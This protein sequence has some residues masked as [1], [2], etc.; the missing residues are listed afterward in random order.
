MARYCVY[1]GAEES[2]DNPVVNN[3]CLKCRIKR[4]ELVKLK[5]TQLKFDF[6]KI[7]GSVKIGYKWVS[8]NGFEEAINAIVE[9]YIPTIIVSGIGVENISITGYELKSMASWHTVI[10]I[11]MKGVYG[12]KEFTIDKDIELYLNPVKCPRCIM[13]D[14]REFEAVI[15]IRGFSMK[16]IAKLIDR[17]LRLDN[18]LARDLIEVIETGDGVNLYFFNHGAARKLAR[19][20]SSKLGAVIH[21]SYEV[22]GTRSGKQRARL[23]I[24]LKPR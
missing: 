8:T 11:K 7:C 21:E 2:R 20:L 16:K 6:C 15:Q 22:A 10:N 17:E 3:V 9:K 12:G 14:S 19:K 24:S 13:F 5:E 4:N 18:R 23:Y 1:C